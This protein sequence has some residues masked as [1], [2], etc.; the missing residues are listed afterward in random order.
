MLN[1]HCHPIYIKILLSSQI[2]AK[3]LQKSLEYV[4]MLKDDEQNKI[5]FIHFVIIANE[6]KLYNKSVMD[7]FILIIDKEKIYTGYIEYIK[8]KRKKIRE[9]NKIL[10]EIKMTP[11]EKIQP[12]MQQYKQ[13]ILDIDNNLDDENKFEIV[14]SFISYFIKNKDKRSIYLDI[15]KSAPKIKNLFVQKIKNISVILLEMKDEIA[16]LQQ[17]GGKNKYIKK[18]NKYIS[19]IQKIK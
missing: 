10:N 12:K 15:L 9:T 8:N 11:I 14:S 1:L 2:K 3:F 16:E 5:I 4:D 13:E 18:I 17:E 7:N 6:F 19:K